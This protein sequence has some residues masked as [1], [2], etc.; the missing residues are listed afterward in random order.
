MNVNPAARTIDP[1]SSTNYR[2]SFT[3]SGGFNGSIT[4]TASSA[5]PSVTLSLGTIVVTP[6]MIITLTVTDTHN[7]GLWY[8]TFPITATN[9]TVTRTGSIGLLIGGLK[10]YLPIV[11]KN[12]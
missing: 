2:V 1:G 6:S 8:Y 12:L 11:L 4:V 7:S 5:F 3:P 9:S 10:V